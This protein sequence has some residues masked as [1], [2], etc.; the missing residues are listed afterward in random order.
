MP[1]LKKK[2]KIEHVPHLIR[3]LAPSV[4]VTTSDE[5]VSPLP[6]SL[7]AC[8]ITFNIYRPTKVG[9]TPHVGAV[10]MPV[11]VA[12]YWVVGFVVDG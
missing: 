12:T 7:F 10:R 3:T 9:H 1:Y 6:K 11:Y 8:V 4:Q 5:L 2:R